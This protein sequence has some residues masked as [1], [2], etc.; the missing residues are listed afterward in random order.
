M[1]QIIG[2]GAGGHSK[3]VIELARATA[4]YEIVGL[5]DPRPELQ[6]IRVADVPVCGDD[7][8]LKDFRQ[9]G[10]GHAFI[11]VG[12]TGDP[13]R[14][15]LLYEQLRQLEYEV[16]T[17]VHPRAIVSPSATVGQGTTV[18]A[19]SV[20]NASALLGS[21]VIVNS[22]A[23]VEHDCQIRDHS[24]IAPGARLAG[25]VIVEERAFVGIGA[26]VLPGVRLW[27]RSVVAAGAVVTRNVPDNLVVA[28]VPARTI[29]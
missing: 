26:T 15:V 12:A 16:V 13:S 28:G 1:I 8:L 18:M 14:R 3:V 11:G 4:K 17:L 22:G 24:H 6:G 9:Q 20:I 10:I 23:I 29:Q 7:D 25:G 27:R 5:L 19:G 2:L 21:N